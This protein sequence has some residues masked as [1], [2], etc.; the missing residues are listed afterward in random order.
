MLKKENAMIDEEGEGFLSRIIPGTRL[1]Q[2]QTGSGQVK[3]SLVEKAQSGLDKDKKKFAG[4]FEGFFNIHLKE[5]EECI[6]KVAQEEDM[7]EIM[8]LISSS[9]ANFRAN[10]YMVGSETYFGVCS[11][12]L[13]WSESIKEIDNTVIVDVKEVLEGYVLSVKTIES[14]SDL[15][16]KQ[17][18]DLTSAVDKLCFRFFE[19]HKHIFPTQSINNSQKL[20]INEINED[21]GIEE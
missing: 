20:Y 10:S 8:N 16:E 1:L 19:K 15:S 6:R 14:E 13:M 2:T 18:S 7:D 17:I 11:I 12:F 5:I 9:V 21:F 3:E 4:N